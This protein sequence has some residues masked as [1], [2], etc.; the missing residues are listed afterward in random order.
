M[1]FPEKHFQKL[2]KFPASRRDLSFLISEDIAWQDVEKEIK[3]LEIPLEKI[4][5]FDIYRG[6]NI[7]QDKISISFTLI[8][9]HPERTLESEEVE[10]YVKEVM[11]LMEKKFKA[12]LRK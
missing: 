7:P 8:F 10:E 4:E 2:P 1:L 5:V 3:S 6:K 11:E 12:I 9:R